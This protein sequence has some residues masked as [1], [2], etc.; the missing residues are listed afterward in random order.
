MDATFDSL[1]PHIPD[2]SNS[3]QRK[4]SRSFLASVKGL[5]KQPSRTNLEAPLNNGRAPP[6]R[7]T[8]E[9]GYHPRQRSRSPVPRI[10]VRSWGGSSSKGR[11]SRERV[12]SMVDYLTLAQLENVW[13]K[14]DSYRGCVSIPETAP[15]PEIQQMQQQL[16]NRRAGGSP[17]PRFMDIH[18]ALRAKS[19]PLDDSAW[20]RPPSYRQ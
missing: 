4:R 1:Y 18:P 14:Q 13:H 8:S 12:P 10:K 3:G 19:P 16:I 7:P 9:L 11:R 6:S 5:V 17:E 2:S 15:S 20:S